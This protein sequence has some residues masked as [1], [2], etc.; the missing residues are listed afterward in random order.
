LPLK[1]NLQ[2]YS[3]VCI[4]ERSLGFYALGVGKGAGRAAAVITSSGTAVVGLLQVELIQLT[5][6]LKAPGSVTQP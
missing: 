3:V 6:S 5:H 4:D 2:R 1:R